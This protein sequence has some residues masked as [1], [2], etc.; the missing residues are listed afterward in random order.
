MDENEGRD[1]EKVEG[2]ME[3]FWRVKFTGWLVYGEKI[4]ERSLS[5][6]GYEKRWEPLGFVT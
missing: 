6:R 1:E 4:M 5:R 3:H 2:M